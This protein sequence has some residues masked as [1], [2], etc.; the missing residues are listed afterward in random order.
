MKPLRHF[1]IFVLEVRRVIHILEFRS[2]MALLFTFFGLTWL[3]GA[4]MAF[5]FARYM[6]AK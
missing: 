1:A 6:F 4:Y 3:L 5:D 2:A